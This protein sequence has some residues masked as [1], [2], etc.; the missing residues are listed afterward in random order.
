MTLL[1]RLS[2][3]RWEEPGIDRAYARA[4][5]PALTV[6]AEGSGPRIAVL[7]PVCDTREGWLREAIASVRA[8]SWPHWEL[9]IADDVSTAPHVAAILEEACGSNPRIRMVRLAARSGIAAATNAAARL[10]S[11]GYVA[12]LDHDD[13]LAPEALA[14]MA[15]AARAHPEAGLL[16]SDEDQ[17]VGGARRAP[18]VKPGWNPDLLLQ[19]NLVCHLAV[20]RRDLFEALGGMREGY[21]GAQDHD[22]ALRAARHLGPGGVRHVPGVLYHWRQDPGSFSAASA[23][24]CRESAARTIR[25]HAGEGAQFVT[26][27]DLPGWLAVAYPFPGNVGQIAILPPG[28][29]AG[30]DDDGVLVF[31]S[32]TLRPMSTDAIER[33]AAQALQP[34][35]GVAGGRLEDGRGRILHGGDSVDPMRVAVAA[36][37][38]VG[39]PGYRG[40]F[41]L[42]RTVAAV[43]GDCL[44]IRADRFR[45]L[46]GWRSEAG[47]FA[48]V[49]LCLRAA[50]AGWRTVWTPVARFAYAQGPRE[51]RRGRDWMRR[52]WRAQLAADPYLN[53]HLSLRAGKLQWK[54][55]WGRRPQ[56]SAEAE[57]L[58][59]GGKP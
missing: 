39:D 28:A 55:V 6:T 53:P 36:R 58:P 52:Q 44:A 21:E 59:A 22:F 8:Q 19:Q 16:F 32:P 5:H 34:G 26:D 7:M 3:L 11:A 35:V 47:D 23:A 20:C 2:R 33:L 40:R 46:G 50:E 51:R 37:G 29:S 24:R 9:C 15:R 56:R 43:S 25:E 1:E 41:R 45:A 48:A 31:L 38:A 12:F 14:V 13:V 49:D 18:Y 27:P 57:P 10:A 54:G 17:L 42:A 4:P 30:V